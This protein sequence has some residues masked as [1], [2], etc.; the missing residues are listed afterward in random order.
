MRNR[1]ALSIV[2]SA[3][4]PTSSTPIVLPEE[5]Q[6]LFREVIRILEEAHFAYAVAGAFALRQHTGICRFTKDLDIFLN[7]TAATGV[8]E[9]LEPHGFECEVCDP[10]WLAKVRRDNYFIDLIT[11]MS[12]GVI[13]V[14]DSWIERAH[15]ARVCGVDSRVLAPEE[16]LVSKLF[17]TRRERFDGADIA[18][19][20]FGSRGQ[21]QWD[22]VLQL[23]GDH[24]ELLLWSLLLFHYVY[25]AHS[26]YIPQPLWQDLLARLGEEVRKP[27]TDAPFRGSLIDE[28]MF[29]ID[30]EEWGLANLLEGYRERRRKISM[31]VRGR[32]KSKSRRAAG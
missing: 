16:M 17:V 8:L 23:V 31:P 1:K 24:W 5:Q 6:A 9:A 27:N 10:V 11:G 30:V 7:P 20:I 29:A 26:D 18:H 14:D 28:V 22:R 15:P 19:I 3:V 32:S 12:N 4:T 2:E 13:T 21:L 25:P